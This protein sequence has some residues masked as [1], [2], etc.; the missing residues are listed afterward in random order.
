LIQLLQAELLMLH[1]FRGLMNSK[2]EF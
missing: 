2:R 1:R